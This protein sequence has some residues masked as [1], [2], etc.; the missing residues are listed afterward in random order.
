MAFDGAGKPY[1]GPR[2]RG[3]LIAFVVIVAVIMLF[4][5]PLGTMLLDAI[6]LLPSPAR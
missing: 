3:V 6:G 1:K 5:T 2:Y 4:I